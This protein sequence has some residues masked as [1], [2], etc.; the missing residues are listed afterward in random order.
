MNKK[1]K[2]FQRRM[3]AFHEVEAQT[4]ASGPDLSEAAR[5]AIWQRGYADGMA[6]AKRNPEYFWVKG[7]VS[8]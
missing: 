5:I 6:A 3:N 4:S 7:L 1:A 8:R 2:E